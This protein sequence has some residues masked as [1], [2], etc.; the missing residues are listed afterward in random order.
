MDLT[1]KAYVKVPVDVLIM[2]GIRTMGVVNYFLVIKSK[3][4]YI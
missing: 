4:T 2:S 1:V 3:K